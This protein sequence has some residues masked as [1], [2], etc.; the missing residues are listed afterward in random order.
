MDNQGAPSAGWARLAAALAVTGAVFAIVAGI[1]T[2]LVPATAWTQLLMACAALGW[3]FLAAWGPQALSWSH[4]RRTGLTPQSS[5]GGA[6]A[7]GDGSL[8]V[9]AQPD[10]PQTGQIKRRWLG[11]H[12][13]QM[14]VVLIGALGAIAFWLLAWPQAREGGGLIWFGLL[15]LLSFPAL[16]LGNALAQHPHPGCRHQARFTRFAMFAFLVM[17]LATAMQGMALPIDVVAGDAPLSVWALRLMAGVQIALAAEWVLRALISPFLPVKSADR[18]NESLVLSL[19]TRSQDSGSGFEDQFGI[20][21]S[22]SWAVQFVRR[23]SVWMLMVLAVATWMTSA[24]TTLRVDERGIYQRMGQ[25]S[26]ATLEPGLH[27]HL[28]W[29]FGSVRRISYGGIQSVR[30]NATMDAP[31]AKVTAVEAPSA[32]HDDRIWSKDHGEE[33]FLMI[34]NQPRLSAGENYESQRPYE[35]YH[36]DVV[37]TYR[38]G[39]SAKASLRSTYHVADADIL[40][41]QIGRREL[42]NLFKN[43]TAEDLLFADFS[44]FSRAHHSA[45]QERLDALETGI[46]VIDVIFEAVHPPI[47]TAATFERVHAAEKESAVLVNIARAEAEQMS[48]TAQINAART[49]DQAQSDAFADT[50]QARAERVLFSAERAAY[51]RAEGVFVFERALQVFERTFAGKNLII[52]D[53]EINAGQGFVVDLN[54]HAL[55]A[56]VQD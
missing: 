27:V 18:L 21:I 51:D 14:S 37:I 48:A 26:A 52:V 20:D 9:G 8:S 32:N 39:L 13:L 1:L 41:S 36:A 19:I 11:S 45:V 15:A 12:W 46:D 23:S 50:A 10:Q 3:L 2:L 33:L 30:L 43:R 5:V 6:E 25:V 44:A 34:A 17:G 54:D 40:V 47:Q 31:A 24:V 22:Q 28:P 38:A 49:R 16:V 4:M 29:P 35:L 42:I 53:P 55:G 56:S 7:D